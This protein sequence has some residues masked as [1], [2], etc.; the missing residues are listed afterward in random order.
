MQSRMQFRGAGGRVAGALFACLIALFVLSAE[1]AAQAPPPM[2]TADLTLKKA[3]SVDPA[4]AGKTFEY[5]IRVANRGPDAATNVVVTDKLPPGVTLVKATPSQGTCA[6]QGRTVTCDLG[7]LDAPTT[8][9]GTVTND[10]ATVTLKVRAPQKTGAIENTAEVTSNATDPNLVNNT[11]TETTQVE[12]KPQPAVPNCRGIPAT[13]V[14]TKGDDVLTGTGGRD[15]IL[16]RGGDDEIFARGGKDVICAGRGADVVKAGGDDDLVYGGGGRDR[17][18]GRGGDDEIRGQLRGDRLRGGR[19][20]DL[21]VGGPGND[22][23]RGGAG[24]DTERGC[25]D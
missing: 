15:V 2:T 1:G 4:T 25:E 12:A 21:L 19:G 20:D 7:R 23:C 24:N 10:F 6:T 17:I 13:I 5:T 18:A 16:G 14:G 8:T 11:D 3:D 9:N 22:R